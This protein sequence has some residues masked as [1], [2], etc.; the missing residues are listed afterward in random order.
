MNEC[1]RSRDSY[2]MGTIDFMSFEPSSVAKYSVLR[3][4]NLSLNSSITFAVSW[5]IS[6]TAFIFSLN[7]GRII[8][9]IFSKSGWFLK[10]L[11]AVSR[12]L[13][14]GD[15]NTV[16][17]FSW[18]AKSWFSSHCSTPFWVIDQSRSSAEI[19]FLTNSD[20]SATQSHYTKNTFLWSQ[21]EIFVIV[22]RLSMSN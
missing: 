10:R 9:L 13:L 7:S 18:L 20:W 22:F 3:L 4:G 6:Q 17:T 14:I 19:A 11:W 16:W 1:I 5:G 2:I 12:V 8:K 15:M 21:F